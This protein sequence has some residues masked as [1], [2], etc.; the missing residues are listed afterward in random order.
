MLAPASVLILSF[1]QNTPCLN[2]GR[3]RKVLAAKDVACVDAEICVNYS[4]LSTEV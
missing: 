2:Y 1:V 4:N 3:S